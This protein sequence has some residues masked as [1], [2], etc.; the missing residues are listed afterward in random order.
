MH[1]NNPE[2]DALWVIPCL[3]LPI[4]HFIKL[5]SLDLEVCVEAEL[6]CESAALC[7]RR[8]LM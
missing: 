2:M 1:K 7:Q 8:F 6:K 3:G 4:L 5:V